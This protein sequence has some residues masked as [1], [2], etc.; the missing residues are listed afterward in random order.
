[1]G[2]SFAEEFGVVMQVREE[3]DGER[4]GA[5]QGALGELHA[6]ALHLPGT[7]S[8]VGDGAYASEQGEKGQKE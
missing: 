2:D 4:A 7:P 3:G 5:G 8:A 1:M 6:V